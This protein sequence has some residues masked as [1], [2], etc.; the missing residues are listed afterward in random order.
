MMPSASQVMPLASQVLD[1]LLKKA[2]L[3]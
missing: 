1:R 2:S 3:S